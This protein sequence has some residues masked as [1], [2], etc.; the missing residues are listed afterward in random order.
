MR[1][2]GHLASIFCRVGI[3]L[4][5]GLLSRCLSFIC[6]FQAEIAPIYARSAKAG[7]DRQHAYVLSMMPGVNQSQENKLK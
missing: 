5:D 3:S 2:V 4:G 7:N 6:M 1:V